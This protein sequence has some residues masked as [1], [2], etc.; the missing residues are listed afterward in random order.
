MYNIKLADVAVASS[1]SVLVAS[2]EG[3]PT[4]SIDVNDSKP[5]GIYGLT[6]NNFINRSENEP[7]LNLVEL[8]EQVLKNGVDLNELNRNCPKRQVDYSSHMRAIDKQNITYY[9]ITSTTMFRHAKM[10]YVL[11]K[12]LGERLFSRIV[13]KF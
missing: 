7:Q 5:I 13:M 3:V 2:E 11:Q 4:I 6:T 12:I 8:L 9:D 1:G 10:I